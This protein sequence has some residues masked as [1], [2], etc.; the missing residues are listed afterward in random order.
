MMTFNEF[1]QLAENPPRKEEP[2]IF[3]VA[4]YDID[5]IEMDQESE[6]GDKESPRHREYY[7][8][9]PLYCHHEVLAATLPDAEAMMR[10]LFQDVSKVYCAVVTELPFGDDIRSD[11]VSVRVYDNNGGLIDSSKSSSFFTEERDDYRHFR[12]RNPKEIRFAEDTLWHAGVEGISSTA[13]N[14]VCFFRQFITMVCYYI[15]ELAFP[16][17]A[18]VAISSRMTHGAFSQR[19]IV[20]HSWH[21]L[22][23]TSALAQ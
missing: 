21:V 6:N 18:N 9:F 4:V 11:Y 7:P 2:T 8:E 19:L 3:K 15:Q 13:E 10:C 20:R 5:T 1:R 14:K 23:N 17:W 16:Q 22:R 12:G